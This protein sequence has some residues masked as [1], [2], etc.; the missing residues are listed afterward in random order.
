MKTQ[1]KVRFITFFV[2]NTKNFET[3]RSGFESVFNKKFKI[4]SHN[5]RSKS[6]FCSVRIRKKN[7]NPSV[8]Q[9]L[10]CYL[11]LTAEVEISLGQPN[12]YS[13]KLSL[14]TYTYNIHIL[15]YT[16]LIFEGVIEYGER[17]K[18]GVFLFNTIK[19]PNVSSEGQSPS[20][21]VLRKV[22]HNFNRIW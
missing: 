17:R 16:F 14:N 21:K 6:F 3:S 20:N 1:A 22:F 2:F 12:N 9:L 8:Y 15:L 4:S 13:S 18:K 7:Y 5:W 10:K 11:I 19:S